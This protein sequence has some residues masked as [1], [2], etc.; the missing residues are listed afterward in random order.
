MSA[1]FS[2]D[3]IGKQS[4]ESNASSVAQSQVDC[5]G[6]CIHDVRSEALSANGY[7][8]DAYDN[9]GE[10]TPGN[11]Y[12]KDVEDNEDD[13]PA[14]DSSPATPKPNG[15]PLPTRRAVRSAVNARFSTIALGFD[16][17]FNALHA[18]SEAYSPTVVPSL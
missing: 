12:H 3:S 17:Y 1:T 15:A 11:G 2:K 9:E 18:T 6:L 7:H 14:N 4:T 16:E 13:V 10:A 5:R 8:E